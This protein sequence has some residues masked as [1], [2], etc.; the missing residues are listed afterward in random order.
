[1]GFASFT[2]LFKSANVELIVLATLPILKRVL[3]Q[4]YLKL[5]P[6][7]GDKTYDFISFHASV[8]V[9]AVFV[10]RRCMREHEVPTRVPTRD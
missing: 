1:M 3:I 8:V 9:N 4:S 5:K 6:T 7:R 2:F 10:D